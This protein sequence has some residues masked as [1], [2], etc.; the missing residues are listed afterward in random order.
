MTPEFDL[1]AKYFSRVPKRASLGVGDDCALLTATPGL[2]MAISTDTLVA[3]THFFP[4]ADPRDLGHKAL[5]VNLSDLAAM[6][7]VPR[8]V[9][10]ALTL[11]QV[12]DAWLSEFAGG[13]W[14]LANE[15]DV[16]LIG[17]DTT[18]GP[19]SMTLTVI[20]EVE[21]GRALKRSGAK[22][23]DDLWVSSTVGGAALALMHMK[24][25]VRLA[26]ADASAMASL[27]HRPRPRVALG[28]AL[29]G[30]ANAAI[31]ISDGLMADVGHLCE[32]SGLGAVIEWDRIPMPKTLG[33][34][35]GEI[36]QACALAG[37]D[38]YEL[39]FTAPAAKRDAIAALA[40]ATR[41]G[42]MRRDVNGVTVIDRE[43]RTMPLSRRGYD[44]FGAAG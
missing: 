14:A 16:D 13:F 26:D 35:P 1:I 27:L 7:A 24:G 41:I 33:E 38:D 2:E 21:Q 30:L 31:D 37:G 15:Y 10:L 28:R 29:Q 9:L 39:A 17:G 22:A 42:A 32:C 36:R 4:D 40:Q 20:G 18:R 25:Q 43:G 44:H 8:A 34:Q 23:D 19:L 11:P 5:A 3:G 6:G 12:N